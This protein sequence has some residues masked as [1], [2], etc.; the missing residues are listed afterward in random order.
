MMLSVADDVRRA[1]LMNAEMGL[2][3]NSC[4]LIEVLPWHI[5]GLTEENF[6]RKHQDSS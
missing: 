5:R 1:R 3:G 4:G 6:E 2:E